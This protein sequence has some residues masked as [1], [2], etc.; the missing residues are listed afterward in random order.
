MSIRPFRPRR[1]RGEAPTAGGIR[2][3]ASIAGGRG[4]SGRCGFLPG[5]RPGLETIAKADTIGALMTSESGS[6][7]APCSWTLLLGPGSA[8]DEALPLLETLASMR[9]A[10][11]P[12][13]PRRLETWQALFC[14]FPE[15]GRIVVD[16]STIE[17]KH[18]GLIEAFLEHRPSWELILLG[19]DP[20]SAGA[21]ELLRRPGVSWLPAPLEVRALETLLAP[22]TPGPATAT[23]GGDGTRAEAPAQPSEEIASPD[24]E[25]LSGADDLTSR[26]EAILRGE[27]LPGAGAPAAARPPAAAAAPAARRAPDPLDLG[28]FSALGDEAQDALGAPELPPEPGP[29]EDDSPQRP[30]PYFRNQ[31]ADLADLVQCIDHSLEAACDAEDGDELVLRL[32]DLRLEVARLSQ[33]TRTLSFLAAPPGPGSQ[34]FDLAPMLGEMLTARGSEPE[35]PRYLIRT[36]EGE[37]ALPVRSDRVL[38]TQALDAVLFL[39]HWC[40]SPG[41]TLRV[42]GRLVEDEVRVS[43]RFPAGALADMNLGRI[44]EPYGLRRR[45]PELG[46]NAL[47]AA[48]GI[49]QGQGGRLELESDGDGGLE[50]LLHLPAAE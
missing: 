3:R 21:R 48:S 31:V 18:V 29:A 30:A 20:S 16:T 32:E 1:A 13:G 4:R 25:P 10:D 15:V 9:G 26:V 5:A 44:L 7:E 37:D 11:R 12:H 23:G 34:R 28:A 36:P 47:A 24:A 43:I 35:A 38:L 27:D 19:T 46:A 41:G 33:F 8:L 14:E 22:P 6:P 40:A 45:L 49:L 42:D 39:G 2:E 17:A 50:W